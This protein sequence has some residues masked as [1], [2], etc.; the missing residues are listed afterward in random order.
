MRRVG[1]ILTLGREP[2][3]PEQIAS[4]AVFLASDAASLVNGVALPDDGGRAMA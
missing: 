4:E 3:E 2:V 1:L